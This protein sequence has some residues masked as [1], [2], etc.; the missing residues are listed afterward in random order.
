MHKKTRT[1]GSAARRENIKA[2]ATRGCVH[3]KHA[4][5]E[6]TILTVGGWNNNNRKLNSVALVTDASCASPPPDNNG[7]H[8]GPRYESI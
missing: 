1:S 4:S 7:R 3:D 6:R 8:K 5:G 2:C